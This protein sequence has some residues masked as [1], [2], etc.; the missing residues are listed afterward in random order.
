V[1][2]MGNRLVAIT[3][4]DGIVIQPETSSNAQASAGSGN[5]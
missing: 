5:H 1:S 3:P 4:F 2:M